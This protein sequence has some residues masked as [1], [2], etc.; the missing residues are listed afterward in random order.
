M[1]HRADWAIVL[2]LAVTPFCSAAALNAHVTTPAGVAVE[3]A[4]LVL[5]PLSESAPI[6]R[7]T[8]AVK[9]YDREFLPY[10][11]VVQT[12]TVVEFPNLDPIMHH[13]YSFSPA[14]VFEIK[15]YA[16]K[17]VPPV[18]FDT[19]GVVVLGCNIHDWMEA[20]L[21]VV[22]TPYF[23][24]TASNGRAAITVSAGYYRLRVWHPRQKMAL[25][26]KNVEIGNNNK[27]ALHLALDVAPRVAKPKPPLDA[28]SY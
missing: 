7:K 14:K 4:A 20:Y 22:N 18:V 2:T 5:E 27:L 23:A 12:G 25:A 1:I 3:D 21:L 17:P 11:T 28:E 6:R 19:P 9:Q 26:E 24:K 16:R 8:V 10:L 15:L 13:V